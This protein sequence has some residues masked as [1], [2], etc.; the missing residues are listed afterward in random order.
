MSSKYQKLFTV[1][2]GFPA[3]LKAFTREILRA[4]PPSLYDFGAEYFAR[5]LDAQKTA[6]P[7][8][9]LDD[10]AKHVS[11]F[12]LLNASTSEVEQ[13]VLQLFLEADEDQSGY[14]DRREFNRVM[15]SAKL[16][17]NKKQVRQILAE[18]D[19]NDD[20]VI[21]YREFLPIMLD[22]IASM[23]A[24]QAA[25]AAREEAEAAARDYV[26]EIMV[27]GM[28]P[29]QLEAMMRK[30]FMKADA[31]KNGHLT[32]DEF[33]DCLKSAEL[34][35]TRKDINTLLSSVDLNDDG[36][37]T[38]EEF[39]PLCRE[40]IV[41]RF[42]EEMLT[43]DILNSQ[44]GLQQELLSA[45]QK[46]DAEGTGKLAPKRARAALEALSFQVLGLTQFQVL[47]VM[48]QA[49]MTPEGLVDYVKF[50][51]IA[52][53]IVYGM[54]DASAMKNRLA[55]IQKLADN[56]SI[57]EL[58]ALDYATLKRLLQGVFQDADTEGV[59]E[60][61]YDQVVDCIN[62]L[63]WEY[64][65]PYHISTM[66]SAIDADGNGMVNWQ[67]LANFLCDVLEHVERERYIN[68]V[69]WNSAM[70]A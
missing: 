44:D 6:A 37:I 62:S 35:L 25:A 9:L 56:D 66:I 55:A 33:K 30:V 45:F 54:F 3:V 58:A 67:E 34:G 48:S 53:H 63:S 27:H 32:Y 38:Y 57:A 47:S 7:E 69:A 18:C 12:D 68:D 40:I 16:G 14:L 23:K 41:E 2:E 13:F 8:S 61:T 1:P 64:L 31:D 39:I 65:S 36:V 11:A 60:L 26:E 49:P 59:G 50:V 22:V 10:L 52:A 51:P 21:E 42:K 4:Q 46:A 43:N 20:G 19:E 24:A 15:R 5:L 70:S 17:L 28:S 29:K